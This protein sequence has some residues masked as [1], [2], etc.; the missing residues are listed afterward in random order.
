MLSNVLPFS[1]TF[2]YLNIG[3][4]ATHVPVSCWRKGV[5]L[6]KSEVVSQKRT[7]TA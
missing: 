2:P 5:E 3:Y 1:S 6:S 4:P 7:G